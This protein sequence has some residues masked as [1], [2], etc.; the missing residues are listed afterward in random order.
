MQKALE[1]AIEEHKIPLHAYIN[2]AGVEGPQG[3][4]DTMDLASFDATLAINLRGAFLGIKHA[5][6]SGVQQGCLREG[7]KPCM[8]AALTVLSPRGRWQGHEGGGGGG[9]NSQR[10]QHCRR[11]RRLCSC[12]IHGQQGCGGRPD[13]AGVSYNP[14]GVLS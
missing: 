4:I 10:G 3:P 13:E 1:G 7:H 6:R 12:A 14:A 2:C 5:A 8:H 9:R 11:D